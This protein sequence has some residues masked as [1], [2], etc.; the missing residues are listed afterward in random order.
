MDR[1]DVRQALR[2]ALPIVLGY[3]ALGLPCGILGAKAGMNVIMVAVLSVLLYSGSGQYMIAGM[4][5]AGVDPITLSLSVSLVNSRQLLYGSAL[6]PF[7]EDIEKGKLTFFAATVTDESFGI[8][9]ARFEN[10]SWSVERATAVNIECQLTWALSNVAGVLIGSLISLP[11]AIASFA[12]TSIFICLLCMQQVSAKNL[13]AAF[14]AIIGVFVCKCVG[15]SGP[16]ILIGAL[17]GVG[18]GY[19]YASKTEKRSSQAEG[20]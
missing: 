2:A 8:N 13:I 7:F 11:T 3:V 4:F 17:I 14:A 6:S 15:L 5:I 9:L 1:R 10:G 20:E 16:A 18:A 12:M 19:L